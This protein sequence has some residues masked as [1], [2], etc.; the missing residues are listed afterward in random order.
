MDRAIVLLSGG[1]DSLV[2]AGIAC[3]ENDEVCF[4]HVNYGQKTQE[5]ELECFRQLVLHYRPT[6]T[7]IV[8]LNWLGE[9]GGSAL[10][11]DKITIEDYQGRKDA[12]LTYVPFRNA[13]LLATAVSWAEVIRANR[14]YIGAVEEDSS[15]YPDCREVFFQS[16]QAAINTGTQCPFPIEIR[17]PVIHLNKADI[18][19]LG[20]KLQVPFEY[21]W[22]CYKDNQ[23]ACGVCDS[24]ALRLKAFEQAGF[25]DP[26]P[27]AWE[28]QR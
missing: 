20:M 28:K 27:Y 15:G 26:I 17:T 16:M 21:S 11:D 7:R 3:R 10:T 6:Q 18:V 22:S 9:I 23:I 5:K 1:M 13:N 12:P 4:L 24:C 25:T 2:T 14:I 19:K 8:D